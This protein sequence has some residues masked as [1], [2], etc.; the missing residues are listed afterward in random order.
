[1][2]VA[3]LSGG[4]D[5]TAMV[6]KWLECGKQLDYII[7]CDTGYEFAEMYEYIDKLD[8]YIKRNFGKQITRLDSSQEIYKWAFEYPIVKGERAGRFRGLPLTI[9]RDYCTRQTKIIPTEKFV[10]ERSPQKFKNSVLIGYTYNEVERGRTTNVAYGV[11]V[12]PLHEWKMN[13][14][15]VT[16]FLKQRGIMNPLYER[17]ERTGCFLCPKQSM[18]SYYELYKHYQKHWQTMKEWEQKAIE[19]DCVN[20]HWHPSYTFEELENK[21]KEK[22]NGVLFEEYD[23]KKDTYALY[24]TCFCKG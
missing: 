20:K 2:F 24:E 3:S 7:F 5:S 21:M 10:R 6:V 23:I 15:E 18:K 14:P 12:Y 16:E 22:A 17:F 1:M 19:L 9:H 8:D 11:A 4:R 13:E